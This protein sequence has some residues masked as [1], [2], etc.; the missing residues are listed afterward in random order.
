MHVDRNLSD[1]HIVDSRTLGLDDLGKMTLDSAFT[2]FQAVEATRKAIVMRVLGG[3]VQ[4][5][6]ADQRM[7]TGRCTPLRNSLYRHGRT[8]AYRVWR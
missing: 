5:L 7:P 8:A 6:R 4:L 1:D 3:Q 2:S